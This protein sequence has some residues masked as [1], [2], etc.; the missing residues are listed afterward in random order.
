M[1]VR[2]YEGASSEGSYWQRHGLST[3]ILVIMVVQ[4][5][6]ALYTGH[7]VWIGD[8]QTHG[9]G[10]DYTDFWTWW[11][12]EYHTSLVADTYGALLLVLLSK[13][14]REQGSPASK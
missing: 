8:Q 11:T 5:A 4:T 7:H 1:G 12:Y 2:R 14:L 9:Q 6:V 3:A 13:R 10:L